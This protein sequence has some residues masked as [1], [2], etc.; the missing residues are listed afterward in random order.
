MGCKVSVE[1]DAGFRLSLNESLLAH[2]VVNCYDNN[3]RSNNEY[4]ANAHIQKYP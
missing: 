1:Y 4:D 2:G 3:D